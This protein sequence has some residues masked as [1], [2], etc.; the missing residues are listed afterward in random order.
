MVVNI[1][2]V[3]NQVSTGMS[4]VRILRVFFSLPVGQSIKMYEIMH[5]A[6]SMSKCILKFTLETF[7]YLHTL[8]LC[9]ISICG[10]L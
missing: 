5:L 10:V 4:Q 9:Y 3:L 2:T 7:F 8:L 1:I 6:K